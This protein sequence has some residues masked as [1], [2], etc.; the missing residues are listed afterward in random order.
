MSE[1]E[2]VAIVDE[3]DV[4]IG[5]KY[6]D[7]LLETDCW[8]IVTIWIENS[9]GDILLQQRSPLKK[10]SPNKWTA[11]AAGTIPKGEDYLDTAKREL[12]E[13]IGLSDHEL[14]PLVK[15]HVRF[16]FGW[17]QEQIYKVICDWDISKF[18]VQTEEVAQLEWLTRQQLSD[19]L[20]GRTE[21]PR[22]FAH[23]SKY[24]PELFGL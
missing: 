17:R 12:V 8:R 3:N 15:M 14:V 9:R 16:G 19:E 4:I 18:T 7:E 5:Y 22:E 24:W 6:R 11:A 13:E 23:S 21:H 10:L 20:H 2:E 1:R